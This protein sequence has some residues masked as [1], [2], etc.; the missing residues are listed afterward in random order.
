[1]KHILSCL[2]I[3]IAL[4]LSVSP[5]FGQIKDDNWDGT[6]YCSYKKYNP[7]DI[8]EEGNNFDIVLSFQKPQSSEDLYAAGVS[9]DIKQ[10]K[11]LKR[12]GLINSNPN[13]TWETTIAIF[14]ET[15]TSALRDFS[16]S[17]SWTI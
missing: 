10:L 8:L 14:D 3:S 6:A 17:I 11:F 13:G 7:R 15:Q 5:L 4:I 12:N 2:Y 9:C 1:M 16:K